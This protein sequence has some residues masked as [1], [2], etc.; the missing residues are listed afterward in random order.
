MTGYIT[1][2]SGALWRLPEATAWEIIRTDGTSCDSFEVSFP[3]EAADRAALACATRFCAEEDGKPVFTG[4]I[5]EVAVSLASDG[6]MATLAGRGLAALL[7]DNQV[8]AAAYAYAQVS[9]ILRA[10]VTPFGITNVKSDLK[11]GV[12]SFAV[13]SGDTAWQ[14][15]AGFCLH[16]AGRTPRFLADGTLDLTAP[17]SAVRWKLTSLAGAREIVWRECRYGVISEQ[18]MVDR[19]SGLQTSVKNAAFAEA[20]GACRRVSAAGG[21]SVRATGRT[22]AQRIA[23]SARDYRVLTVTLPG[24]FLAEPCDRIGV[25]LPPLGLEGTFTVREAATRLGADGLTCTLELS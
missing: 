5:D 10:Y 6:R 25:A 3:C 9:D 7:M 13:D 12:S 14:A 21:A 22:A 18:I 16:A 23:E 24:G 17:E 2:P 8:R 20:G 1:A 11:S 15:L 19:S 4:V